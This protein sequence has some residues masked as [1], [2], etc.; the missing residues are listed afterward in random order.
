MTDLGACFEESDFRDVAT[1]IQSGNVVD[2]E[3]L[4]TN[5]HS[6]RCPACSGD[7]AAFRLGASSTLADVY[8]L[9]VTTY[10]LVNGDAYLPDPASL[11]GS[12]EEATTSGAYPNRNRHRAYVPKPVRSLLSKAMAIDPTGRFQS[13]AELRHALEKA[14]PVVSWTEIQTGAEAAWQGK[15]ST[16]NWNAE[17][18]P[19]GGQYAFSVRR[20]RLGS[21]TQ[22]RVVK[23]CVSFARLGDVM[24][25]AGKVLQRVGLRGC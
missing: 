19:L 8:A 17:V 7:G 5:P 15:S 23:D 10:R 25:H 20:S 11:A 6:G 22:K 4:R 13:A 18:V 16:Q 21:E 14:Q 12:L 3:I 1:Y 24:K 2:L 9:G